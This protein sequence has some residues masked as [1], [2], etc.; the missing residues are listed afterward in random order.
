MK[1]LF[2][3]VPVVC[4]LILGACGSDESSEKKVTAEEKK[5][6]PTEAFTYNKIDLEADD[7][8]E[9]DVSLTVSEGYKIDKADGAEIEDW[10]DGDVDL[11]GVIAKDN[12]KADI[13]ITATNGEDT[14]EEIITIDNNEAYSAVARVKQDKKDLKAAKKVARENSKEITYKHLIKTSDGYVGTEYYIAK[15]KVVQAFEEN[16]KTVLMV[17]MSNENNY[18]TD[19][20]AIAYNGTTDV[21]Q[22]DIVEVYGYVAEQY[23]YQTKIGG[24]NTVPLIL[25]SEIKILP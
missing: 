1:K 22:D 17:N 16:G 7:D 3:A 5:E 23:T 10:G 20:I 9:F 15:A 21:I 13:T 18:W 19:L 4:T 14:Q 2:L 6:K 24:T 25:A 8:G 11:V 12:K